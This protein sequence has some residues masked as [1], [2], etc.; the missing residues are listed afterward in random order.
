MN[1]IIVVIEGG[2]VASIF[3]R[4]PDELDILVVDCDSVSVGDALSEKELLPLLGDEPLQEVSYNEQTYDDY[5]TNNSVIELLTNKIK[6]GKNHEK[7]H[8]EQME[9]HRKSNR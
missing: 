6:G 4:E 5:K 1:K 7:H 8:K 2:M 3:A 9:S